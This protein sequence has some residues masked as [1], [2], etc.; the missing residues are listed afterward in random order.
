[1]FILLLILILSTSLFTFNAATSSVTESMNNLNAIEIQGF[2]EPIVQYEGRQLGSQVKSL[3][4]TLIANAGNN[5]DFDERL[6]DIKYVPGE[7]PEVEDDLCNIYSD[8][9]DIN[10]EAMSKLKSQIAN[11]HYYEIEMSY[12]SET[13]LVEEI[14]INY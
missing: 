9:F 4:A 13:G 14:I 12:N 8:S 11:S 5:Q 10:I 1:M 6:P 3:L 2:N 7:G